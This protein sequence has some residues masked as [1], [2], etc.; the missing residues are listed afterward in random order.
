M[1]LPEHPRRD[2]EKETRPQTENAAHTNNMT[3]KGSNEK[4]E[5]ESDWEMVENVTDSENPTDQPSGGYTGHF[6]IDVGW[7]LVH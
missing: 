6:S 1:S 3:R 7:G 4:D 2:I 5:T